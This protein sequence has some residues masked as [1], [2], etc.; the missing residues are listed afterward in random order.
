MSALLLVAG[1]VAVVLSAMVYAAC[2]VSG[3]L[4]D[5]EDADTWARWP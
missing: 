2:I 1:V 3:R 5:M 4:S